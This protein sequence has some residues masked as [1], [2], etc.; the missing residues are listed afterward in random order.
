MNNGAP[1]TNTNKN[2]ATN[3]N[4]GANNNKRKIGGVP[5]SGKKAK[6]ANEGNKADKTI[7]NYQENTIPQPKAIKRDEPNLTKSDEPENNSSS[8]FSMPSYDYTQ[9]TPK[10]EH[11]PTT[12]A[13][14]EEISA[15]NM[16]SGSN[17]ENIENENN[18]EFAKQGAK[19]L[20]NAKFGPVGGKAV[21]LAAKT[22]LG[23]KILDKAGKQ[24]GDIKKGNIGPKK[25]LNNMK[26]IA[27]KASNFTNPTENNNNQDE[28]MLE[29]L[30]NAK[31]KNKN[32]NNE[33]KKKKNLKDRLTNSKSNS[34]SDDDENKNTALSGDTF[35]NMPLKVKIIIISIAVIFLF[36]MFFFTTIVAILSGGF[37]NFEDSAGVVDATGN[38]TGLYDYQ[39]DKASTEDAMEFYERVNN[40]IEELNQ[41]GITVNP[42]QVGAVY[43]VLSINVDEINYDY[44]TEDNI[45]YM[46]ENMY[47]NNAYDKD[48][49][50]NNL[51]ERV[52]PYF[53]KN[54]PT[55]SYDSMADEV[56]EYVEDYEDI[57]RGVIKVYSDGTVSKNS[58]GVYNT[59]GEDVSSS[60]SSSNSCNYIIKGVNTSSGNVTKNFSIS[61]LKVRLMQSNGSFGGTCGKALENES[62][63]DFEKYVLGV[64]YAEIGCPSNEN[65]F[66]S[67]L[68]AARSFALSRPS[69]MGNACGLKLGRQNDQWI[70]QIRNSVHDQ[71][72]CDPDQGCS[73]SS[74]G[75]WSQIHS[76]TS[77]G[78]VYKSALP[79]NS[80]C[81]K[82]AK[83]VEGMILVD[84]QGYVIA[85]GYTSTTQNNV[86]A[87]S[88]DYKS[89][90][91][92]HYTK[93]ANIASSNCS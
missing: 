26:N 2:I 28:K 5:S 16:P 36:A 71:V 50:K 56:F 19:Q 85:S 40:V 90:L 37:F 89:T 30:K 63:V 35:G 41:Q 73:H 88:S 27:K 11:L 48:S 74:D 61:S 34:D 39:I 81:R 8:S 54:A 18:K 44:M 7:R 87:K 70:L 78:K 68:I 76:G 93:A 15:N 75:Q 1:K 51:K 43:Y 72:Y 59:K 42:A 13:S 82:W 67:Q 86:F 46:I 83:E 33:S 58:V 23:N 66:K 64:A 38:D 17:K 62:L 31:N 52:F 79:E 57:A 69:A 55:G 45:K 9:D 6:I 65:Y 3:K 20:A 53:Y 60:S 80:N 22:K 47:Y 32:S 29:K 49:I 24:I 12:S 92:S 10:I 91:L 21:D 4:G 25:Q 84:S 77:S 14:T